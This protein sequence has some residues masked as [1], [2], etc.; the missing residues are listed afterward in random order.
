MSPELENR[1]CDKRK[2]LSTS[3]LAVLIADALLDGGVVGKESL[4]KAIEIIVDEI[5]ARKAVGDY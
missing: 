1:N 2:R 4:Q 3:E 5:D